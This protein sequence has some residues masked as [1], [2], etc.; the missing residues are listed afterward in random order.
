MHL[1]AGVYE[2]SE[3]PAFHPGK[4][5]HIL[6]NTKQG[7]QPLGVFG[8]LHPLALERFDL[9][10]RTVVAGE[11]DLEVLIPAAPD[12]HEIQPVPAFPPVLED[13]ALVVAESVPAAT[14]EALIRATGG[15]TLA[16]VRLFDVYR[17]EQVGEGKKSLAYSLAYQAPDR[18]LTDE[19]VAQIREKI[20]L[21]LEQELGAWLRA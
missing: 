18:T 15:A 20:V 3:H 2:P 5:A 6:I 16:S 19:E 1:P 8:E 14:V 9:P 10:D 12:R 4:Q 13:L 7:L 21:R 17:G 11:F